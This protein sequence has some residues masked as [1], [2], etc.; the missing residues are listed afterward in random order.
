MPGKKRVAKLFTTHP[1]TSLE[2]SVRFEL[3][4]L[5]VTFEREHRIG[6]Y[7]VDF[8]V[9]G[10]LIVEADGGAWHPD[11]QRAQSVWAIKKSL[12]AQIRDTYLRQQ[13][14]TV[15]HLSEKAIRTGLFREPL[16]E[17]IDILS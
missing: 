17:A 2:R 14:Y 12:K 4:K 9:N 8:L 15:L 11:D 6:R 7:T 10:A 16:R 1:E 13:G 3:E 5:G